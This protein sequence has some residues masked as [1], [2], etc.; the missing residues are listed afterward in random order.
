MKIRKA[1][2]ED[3]LSILNLVKEFT[4]EHR[5]ISKLKK[6]LDIE[7]VLE[8]RKKIIQQEIKNKTGIIFLAESEKKC[9]GYIFAIKGF[10][11]DRSDKTKVYI[12]DI[13]VE[14]KFRKKG[15]A[16]LLI[17]NLIR[18]CKKEKIKQIFLD[19]DSNNQKVKEFYKILK[20]EEISIKMGKTLK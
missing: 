19:V 12:S 13:F 18:W 8:I 17:S 16:K 6:A 10:F 4:L 7:K 3:I 14:K 2:K 9:V 5:K 11:Y 20:F 15:I 1:H